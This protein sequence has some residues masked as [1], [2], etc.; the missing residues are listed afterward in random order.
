MLVIDYMSRQ[1]LTAQ[2][3]TEFHLAHELMRHRDIHHLPVVEGG[4]IVGIVAER[5]LLLAAAHFG[6]AHVPLAEIMHSPVECVSV[7]ATLMSAARK[8]VVK[9]I[10]SLP[11][12]DAKRQLVGIIT[13]TDI[14]KAMAEMAWL[15]K[16][17]SAGSKARAPARGRPA[18]RGRKTA[19]RRRKT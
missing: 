7:R 11:V 15:T 3:Q 13:E 10:G 5:D 12:V 9:R 8:L 2:P 6:S 19:A 18:T 16:P 17:R 14:F 4:R 1:V